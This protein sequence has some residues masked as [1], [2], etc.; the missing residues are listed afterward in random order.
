MVEENIQLDWCLS[1]TRLDYQLYI[2]RINC[3]INR[4][5][6]CFSIIYQ[7]IRVHDICSPRTF[8][9]QM[10]HRDH[11]A[12]MSSKLSG[13][14]A[15]IYGYIH[16]NLGSNTRSVGSSRHLGNKCPWGTNILNPFKH[17]CKIV[18]YKSRL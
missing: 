4:N 5:T 3:N 18:L 10:S 11:I 12:S 9:P 16:I 7:Y 8:V 2:K 14:V 1:I 6:F 17:M 15:L 13:I